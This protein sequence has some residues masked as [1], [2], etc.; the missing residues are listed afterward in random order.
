MD[1]CELY[2]DEDFYQRI[3][4]IS[5][6]ICRRSDYVYSRK[7]NGFYLNDLGGASKD[8]KHRKYSGAFV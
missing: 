2:H 7:R 6:E 5:E 8:K 3:Q 1:F 4:I